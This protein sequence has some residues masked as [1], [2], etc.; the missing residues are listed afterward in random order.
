MRSLLSLLRVR[1]SIISVSS[2]YSSMQNL[3]YNV[4]RVYTLECTYEH[5]GAA[6]M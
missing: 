5:Y 2:L 6:A 3:I 4:P 1:M